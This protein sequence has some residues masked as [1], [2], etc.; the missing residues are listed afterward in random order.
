[1]SGN[2]GSPV[3]EITGVD[4]PAGGRSWLESIKVAPRFIRK[5][6]NR[7]YYMSNCLCSKGGFLFWNRSASRRT[8]GTESATCSFCSSH[9]TL[10]KRG[11]R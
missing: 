1:M 6:E 10:N 8:T 9:S 5:E 7:P 11:I 3:T 2:Q 4:P